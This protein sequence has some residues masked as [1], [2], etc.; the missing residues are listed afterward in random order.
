MTLFSTTLSPS[1]LIAGRVLILLLFVAAV[2][3]KLRHRPE[4][5]GVVANYRLMPLAW[6]TPTARLIIGLELVVIASLATGFELILGAALAAILLAAFGAAVTINLVRGRSHIDCGCFQGT[7]RQQLSITLVLRNVLLVVAM[8]PI[9][10]GFTLSSP[11]CSQL[12]DG[13]ATGTA[14]FVLQLVAGQLQ[15]VR[16]A[17]VNIGGR[18]A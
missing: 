7:L 4:F 13:V 9:F 14:L 1:L 17:A 5:I 11:S 12:L 3:G 6:A 10:L 8:A 18:H 15:V 2:A 16:A